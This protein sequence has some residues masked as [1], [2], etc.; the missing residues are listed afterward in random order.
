MDPRGL[1]A[2]PYWSVERILGA[3][4]DA[5]VWRRFDWH[6]ANRGTDPLRWPLWRLLNMA[7][8]WLLHGA[9]DEAARA[10]IRHIIDDPPKAT[11]SLTSTAAPARG[12]G[13]PAGRPRGTGISLEEAQRIA[14]EA[15]EYDAEM[16]G[17]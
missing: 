15:E 11:S 12:R 3:V 17:G 14:R 13:S 9:A 1:R 7:E 10:R 2:A 4:S 8:E 6:F 5:G 16:T